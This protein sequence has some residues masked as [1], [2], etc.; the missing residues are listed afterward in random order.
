MNDLSKLKKCILDK[1]MELLILKI[2][3]KKFIYLMTQLQTN[4][5]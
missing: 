4:T 2:N 3:F 5:I 1:A